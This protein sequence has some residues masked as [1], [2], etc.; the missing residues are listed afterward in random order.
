MAVAN[1]ND[2]KMPSFSTGSSRSSKLRRFKA[3]GFGQRLYWWRALIILVLIFVVGYGGGWLGARTYNHG[4][5]ALAST[6]A[7]RQYI[8]NESDLISSIAKTTGASVVSI[9]TTQTV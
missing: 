4:Q 7:K 6:A 3:P 9:D 5:P 2:P 8:S 1:S